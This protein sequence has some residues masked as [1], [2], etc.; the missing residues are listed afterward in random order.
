MDKVIK[1]VVYTSHTGTTATYAKMLGEKKNLAVYSLK[2]ALQALPA[3]TEILYLGW[4]MASMVKGYAKATKRFQV[5]G[6]CGV[7]LGA[8]GSPLES[9]RKNNKIPAETAL[10]TLQ[11]GFD[12]KKLRGMY[13]WMMKLMTKVLTEEIT[14]KPEQ[15]EE[16]QKIL[17]MLQE[18]GSAVSETHLAEVLE[19]MKQ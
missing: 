10:F 8:N 12:I 14:S 9:V 3:K 19:W 11:G 5:R 13:K 1:A 4:L 6:V 17:Q 15:T 16:D 2:E 18:G 7:C